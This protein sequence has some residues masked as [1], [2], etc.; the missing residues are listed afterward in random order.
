MMEKERALLAGG[1]RK[2]DE[3]F[4]SS[5]EELRQLALACDIEVVG[6]ITQNLERIHVDLYFGKGKTEE[7]RER[8]EELQADIVIFN[9]ELTPSQTRNLER[10][11]AL[12][13]IDRSILIMDIFARRAKTKEAQM[14]V[15]MA[16]LKYMLPRLSGLGGSLNRQGGGAGLH[17]KGTGETKLE[18]DRRKIE[19]RIARLERELTELVGRRQNQ[20]QKRE[21]NEI[22]LAALVGYTNAGKSTVMNSVLKFF[23]TSGDKMVLEKDMLFATLETSVR[24]ITTKENRTFLLTDTVGFIS[25]LPHHLIKAFRSTL[26]EVLMADL[27]IQVVDASD[28]DYEKQMT[29]TKETLKELGADNIPVLYAFN[30]TDKVTEE[31]LEVIKKEKEGLNCIFLSAKK[32]ED[33][34]ELIGHVTEVLFEEDVSLDLCLP[35]KDSKWVAFLQENATVTSLDYGEEEIGVTALCRK[36]LYEKYFK[37]SDFKIK[38]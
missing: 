25:R 23:N 10:F 20:R 22:P 33:I 37:N 12:R 34:K 28:A 11:L 38:N 16:R 30:K 26:E 14:Q 7:L 13:V 36:G 19:E 27:L 3:G 4:E 24:K 31:E 29:V 21:K 8:M 2:G 17:N 6:E 32:E 5:M 15:E 1:K 9:E 18:L 35:Y